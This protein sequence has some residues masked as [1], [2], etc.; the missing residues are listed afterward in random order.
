MKPCEIND[1]F[2]CRTLFCTGHKQENEKKKRKNVPY[3]VYV[4]YVDQARIAGLLKFI[5]GLYRGKITCM[6][7]TNERWEPPQEPLKK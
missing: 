1:G 2:H 6:F 3:K 5:T 4:F 7:I